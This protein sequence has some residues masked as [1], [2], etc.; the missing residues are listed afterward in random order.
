DVTIETRTHDASTG[1][2]LRARPGLPPE[3]APVGVPVGTR[4]IVDRLFANVPARLKFMRSEAT[5]VGH[6]METMTRLALV[7]PRVR[8]RLVHGERELLDLPA[9]TLD[10]RVRAILERR[11]PGP[12]VHTEGDLGGIAVQV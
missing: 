8:L 12:F 9:S 10:A 11:S 2:Q 1:L 5:E 7:H 6:C 3:L 4:V